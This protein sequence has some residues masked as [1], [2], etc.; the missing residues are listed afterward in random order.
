M[1]KPDLCGTCR[2]RQAIPGN[3]HIKC[4]TPP[5]FGAEIGGGGDERYDQARKMAEDN[6]MVVRCVWPGSGIYPYAFD[7]NTVF[8]CSNHRE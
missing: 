3:Y 6:N 8:A 1:D 5:K 2:A 4:T 7:P